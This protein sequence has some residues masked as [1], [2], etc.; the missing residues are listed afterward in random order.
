MGVQVFDTIFYV[1]GVIV[2][3]RLVGYDAMLH[4]CNF[5]QVIPTAPL[6]DVW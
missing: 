5:A 3:E 4:C 1:I 2:G 6:H